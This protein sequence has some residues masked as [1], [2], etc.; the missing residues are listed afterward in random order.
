MRTAS[1]VIAS[2]NGPPGRPRRRTLDEWNRVER[3]HRRCDAT[4]PRASATTWSATNRPAAGSSTLGYQLATTT[5]RMGS[6][7]GVGL[8]LH[9]RTPRRDR[10]PRPSRRRRGGDPAQ[11]DRSRR[12]A[13]RPRPTRRGHRARRSGHPSR[14]RTQLRR[15]GRSRGAARADAGIAPQPPPR[16]SDRVEHEPGELSLAARTPGRGWLVGARPPAG[17]D[18]DLDDARDGRR[19]DAPRLLRRDEHDLVA[20]RVGKRSDPLRGPLT[21]EPDHDHWFG[22]AGPRR[23]R[24][25]ARERPLPVPPMGSAPAA[26]PQRRHGRARAAGRRRPH[27]RTDRRPRLAA[28]PASN[29]S[30]LARTSR[31][32]RPSIVRCHRGGRPRRRGPGPAPGSPSRRRSRPPRPADPLRALRPRPRRTSRAGWGGRRGSPSGHRAATLAR[33]AGS[34]NSTTSPIPSSPARAR[35]LAFRGVIRRPADQPERDRRPRARADGDGPQQVSR[36]PS[37]ASGSRRTGARSNRAR[38]ASP[39]NWL[40]RG[41]R[42]GRP[43]PVRRDRGRPRRSSAASISLTAMTGAPAASVAA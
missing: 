9:F 8:S 22:T 12:S 23:D 24:R 13:R 27:R 29:D 41:R 6:G 11:L 3:D 21:V 31:I 36:S 25:P 19:G 32:A 7:S 37:T 40:H 14:D 26:S 2:T 16:R 33:S 39:R 34:A 20:D 35:Q 30:R 43:E 5:T 18:I 38:R 17:V 1:V 4:S 10:R 42:S 28:G 15:R